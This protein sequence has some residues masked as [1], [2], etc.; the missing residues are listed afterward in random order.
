[1]IDKK[2]IT[3]KINERTERNVETQSNQ[4]ATSYSLLLVTGATLAKRLLDMLNHSA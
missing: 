1:M 3:Q 2:K 4:L